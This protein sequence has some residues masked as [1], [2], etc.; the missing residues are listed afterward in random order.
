MQNIL[1]YI[2]VGFVSLFG[3]YIIYLLIISIYNIVKNMI[4]VIE[5]DGWLLYFTIYILPCILFIIFFILCYF[6]G[7]GV[8]KIFYNIFF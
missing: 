3:M 6:L 2:F 8:I 1:A 7:M 4:K 5:T